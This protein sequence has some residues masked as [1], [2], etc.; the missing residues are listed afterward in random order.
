MITKKY[1]ELLLNNT[2]TVVN[3]RQAGGRAEANRKKQCD[4]GLMASPAA[5]SSTELR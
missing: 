1:S 4:G 2:Q 5:D 3:F